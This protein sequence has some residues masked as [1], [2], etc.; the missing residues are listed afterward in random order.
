LHYNQEQSTFLIGTKSMMNGLL[1]ILP[2][3]SLLTA[4]TIWASV[5]TI[6]KVALSHVSLIS[7]LMLRYVFSG[8]IMLPYLRS[9]YRGAR[10]LSWRSWLVLVASSCLLIF[11]QSWS[12]QQVSASWYIIVF[13]SC[14]VLIALCLRYRFTRLS[15]AGLLLT[16]AGLILYISDSHSASTPFNLWALLGT[17]AGML[18]WVAYSVVITRFHSVYDDMQITA[19]CTYIGAVFSIVLCAWSGDTSFVRTSVSVALWTG[20]SGAVMPLS[21]LCYS[22]SMR[23]TEALTI[24]GQYLEPIIG[25]L[26]AFLIFGT[27]LSAHSCLALVLILGGTIAV[28]HFSIKPAHQ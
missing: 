10:Q 20:L 17:F 8:V 25:L 3:L 6:T 27:A 24:F 16:I 26:I 13:S 7:F 21:L 9:L 14:P 1:R 19:I 11:V 5:P 28:T 4:I 2:L 12:I 22:Y 15:I 23:K 18:S